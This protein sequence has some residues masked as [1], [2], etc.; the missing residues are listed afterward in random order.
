MFLLRRDFNS[1]TPTVKKLF[2]IGK[3]NRLVIWLFT[4]WLAPLLHAANLTSCDE[5]TLTQAIVAANSGDTLQFNCHG[6]ISLT[7]PIIID[8]NLTLNATGYQVTLSGDQKV[9]VIQVNPNVTFTLQNLT[10][11]NGQVEGECPENCGGGLLSNEAT[12][13]LINSTFKNNTA[14]HGGAIHFYYSKGS[15]INSTFSNNTGTADSAAISSRHSEVDII[16][17]TLTNNQGN[18]IID[19]EDSATLQI[20]NS[21]LANNFGNNLRLLTGA[22][23]T[24]NLNNLVEGGCSDCDEA[25]FYSTADPL[26]DDTYVLSAT[27]PAID[28]GNDQ[29]CTPSDQRGVTRP[30]GPHCDIGA[31]EYTPPTY[32]STPPPNSTINLGIIEVGTPISNTLQISGTGDAPLAVTHLSVDSSEFSVSP[33]DLVIAKEGNPQNVTLTCTPSTTGTRSTTLTITHNAPTSPATYTL[34]CTGFETIL[35]SPTP[36]PNFTAHFTFSSTEAS[37]TFECELDNSGFTSCNSPRNYNNLTDG[38]HTFQ[39]RAKVG[40]TVDQSPASYTW[41][42]ASLDTMLLSNPSKDSLNPNANFTFGSLELNATFEC[43]L[44]NGGFATCKNPKKYKNLTD[45]THTFQVRAK[46]GN[47]LDS[48]P[49]SYTWT[50]NTTGP[51]MTPPNTSIT[52]R[53]SNPTP[54]TEATFE[55]TSTEEPSTFECSLDGSPFMVCTSPKTYTGLNAS[56]HLFAVRATDGADN[57]DRSP[58]SYA[59]IIASSLEDKSAWKAAVELEAPTAAQAITNS[60]NQ[61]IITWTD[62]SSDETGFKL[63]RNGDELPP[64]PPQAGVGTVTFSDT[65]VLCGT[66]YTYEIMATNHA[67]DSTPLAVTVTTP[68]CSLEVQI[69]GDGNGQVSSNTGLFC[70]KEDC[71]T[72][73]LDVTCNANCTTKLETN[74]V[75]TPEAEAGSVFNRWG[76]NDDCLDG[77]LTSTSNLL[78]IAYFHKTYQKLNITEVSDGTVIS[79]PAGIHCGET[80]EYDFETGTE[81]TL[82]FLPEV[83]WQLTGWLGSC[84]PQGQVIMSHDAHCSPQLSPVIISPDSGHSNDPVS[85]VITGTVPE[86]SDQIQAPPSPISGAA[87]EG[88]DQT[89]EPPSSSPISAGD[90]SKDLTESSSPVSEIEPATET[91]GQADLGQTNDP[92]T[93]LDKPAEVLPHTDTSNPETQ[94][95]PGGE[96][97]VPPEPMTYP[98]IIKSIGEGIVTSGEGSIHC[99]EICSQSYLKGT[100]VLLT[101]QAI[102]GSLFTGWS[103][104]CRGSE[105]QVTLEITEATN[106]EARFEQLEVVQPQA[107][108]LEVVPPQTLPSSENPPEEP[109]VP[110]SPLPV[111]PLCSLTGTSNEVCTVA[112]QTITQALEVHGHLSQGVLDST[113]TNYGWVSNLTITANGALIGGVVSGRVQNQG[114][115]KDFEFVGA[116]IVGGHLGGKILNHSRI[117]GYFQDVTLE[118][119]THLLGGTLKGTIKGDP[120]APALLENVRVKAGTR[121]I[122][123]KLGRGVILEKGV[124]L[125]DSTY[126]QRSG[127]ARFAGEIRTDF[128][129]LG[130]QLSIDEPE[131]VTMIGKIWPSPTHLGK[132][133]DILLAY[134]WTPEGS[135]EPLSRLVTIAEQRELEEKIEMTLFKGRLIGLAGTLEIDLGYKIDNDFLSAAILT[136]KIHPNRPPTAIELTGTKVIEHSPEEVLVGTLTTHDLDVQ[137]MFTYGLVENPGQHFKIVGNEL[138]TTAFPTDF[139]KEQE[140]TVTVRSTDLA[141]TFVE[142]SFTIKVTDVTG[143]LQDI[144]LTHQS[145]LESSPSGTVVGRFL[146]IG[147]KSQGFTYELLESSNGLFA[148]EKDILVVGDSSR[149]D[150]EK[151]RS[152]AIKVRGEEIESHQALEKTFTIDLVNLV[153]V[154]VDEVAV[155]DLG[156]RQLR[157]SSVAANEPVTIKAKI[158]P[159]VEHLGQ[160]AELF[161]VTNFVQDQQVSLK[162][163]VG[164]QWQAWD[165]NLST[166]QGVRTVTLQE[167]VELTLWSGP[168]A[169]FSGGKVEVYVGYRLNDGTV[170]YSLRP[171]E[172]QVQ[173]F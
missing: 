39:V 110:P 156:G 78:C 123:V 77:N 19:A 9:R 125:Q 67:T 160:T 14:T 13:N 167:N 122:G 38:S 60:A 69:A 97:N 22:S 1:K 89:Q 165:G 134:H 117:G 114:L 85:P 145:V 140:Y 86:S 5:T 11:A 16:H 103:G 119:G 29:V 157:L 72:N 93:K 138:R 173:R 146:A 42:V 43:D 143:L 155:N 75:L 44:D 135:N 144:L 30:Q 163:L 171:F 74:T 57:T 148:L 92:E 133:A 120:Q 61:V 99:G 126:V 65:S 21:L 52:I 105:T 168:L 82:T 142:Q 49:A 150:F 170:T 23:L 68:A 149:L 137:E 124:I 3:P 102:E 81:V 51:D 172:I 47:I 154:G 94:P 158:V 131:A 36:S 70:R 112:G 58:A 129:R 64:A 56:S 46:V 66:T 162:M 147:E 139:E 35:N 98:L 159:D 32:N 153:D 100:Q 116:F 18:S 26:L 151:Q 84:S 83:G 53:P 88:A 106:C 118:S 8:K 141:G 169:E 40:T 20:K 121:L 25:T 63:F 50:I 17:A 15:L 107:L 37:A 87:P 104:S 108:L 2:P 71:V 132:V 55:F 31:V 101:A 166:L 80:C 6:T 73:N 28:A 115:M 113:L 33:T 109:A 164:T 59:W 111:I 95:K 136:L 161:M 79:S 128:G 62:N 24:T 34:Q 96:T 7:S 27:S 10:I 130:T 41:N 48:T 45:G 12:V 91:T 76:G 90:Q 54:S 127:K 4:W 152:Y